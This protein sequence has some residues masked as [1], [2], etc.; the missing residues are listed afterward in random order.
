[1]KTTLFTIFLIAFPYFSQ[2]QSVLAS[3]QEPAWTLDWD[4]AQ[5]LTLYVGEHSFAYTLTSKPSPEGSSDEISESWILKGENGKIAVLVMEFFDPES[6][7]S[8]PC[9]HDMGEGLNRGKAYLITENGQFFIG[10]GEF[11]E[12]PLSAKE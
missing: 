11:L 12:A 10:C 7:E 5:G 3:G 1:M 8:C 4:G 2:A 9:F 6:A